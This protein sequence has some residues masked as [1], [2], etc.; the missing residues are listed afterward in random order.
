MTDKKSKKKQP[1]R[2]APKRSG[3]SKKTASVQPDGTAAVQA[4]GRRKK[5]KWIRSGFDYPLFTIVMILMAFGLI[6]MFSASY[7]TAYSNTGDSLYYVKRQLLFAAGG[8]VAMLLL[9]SFDYHLFASK[10]ILRAIV[11][12]SVILMLLVKV[13][14][15]TQGG[16]EGW[17][18]FGE[19]TFQPSEIL[20]FA[21][22]VFFWLSS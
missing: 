14:G 1:I 16:A 6:M 3:A 15:T 20:K 13:M 4:T 12:V 22:I 7:V 10:L 18:A 5:K 17:L 8:I 11:L 21:V 19:F 9:S 2:L